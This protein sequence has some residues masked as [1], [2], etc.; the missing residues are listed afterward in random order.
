MNGLKPVFFGFDKK[1]DVYATDVDTKGL[2]GT[3]FT[4][5]TPKGKMKIRVNVPGHHMVSNA[6]AAVAIGLE[7]G[8][9]EKQ[10][11]AGVAAFKP[12]SGHS[13]IVETKHFTIMDDCYN[14]NPV[15]TKAGIDVL[16]QTD[17]R[18]VAILGDMFELGADE[19]KMHYEVGEYA[20][21]KGIDCII[22]AGELA[23]E[24]YDGAKAAGK[25]ENLYYFPSRD[26]A[27]ENLK[28]IVK[29]NDA[30]LVK[31][32]HGMKFEKIVEVLKQM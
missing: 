18:K 10:I 2:A 4:A 31:A 21:K 16:I 5:V 11:A 14:A 20:A 29:A 15:S 26:E 23:K 19:R 8:L 25:K 28:D 6:L 17:E 12:V 13:S 27:I 24:Y 3:S 7:L 1:N 32:S 30:I 9:N 22:C